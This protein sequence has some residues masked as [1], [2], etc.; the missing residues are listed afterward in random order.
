MTDELQAISPDHF[1]TL[2]LAGTL[3][4]KR[5]HIFLRILA[6]TANIR[7]AARAAGYNNTGAINRLKAMNPAFAAAIQEAAE[8]AADMLEAEAVRRATQGVKKQVWF[9][10]EPVGTEIVYSDSLLALL[11]KAAKP[12]KYADRTKNESKINLTGV[13]GIAV[14]PMMARSVG[15][16]EKSSVVVRDQ[17]RLLGSGGGDKVIDAEFTEA[18]GQTLDRT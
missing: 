6:E 16:W 17:Q 8:A 9:K 13:V 1:D 4:E 3:D 12:D 15:D 7:L 10:G 18:K 14:V 11:L 2:L 5:Q